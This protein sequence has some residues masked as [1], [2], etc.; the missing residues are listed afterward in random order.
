MCKNKRKNKCYTELLYDKCVRCEI[1]FDNVTTDLFCNTCKNEVVTLSN[2]IRDD[3]NLQKYF[4]VWCKHNSHPKMKYEQHLVAESPNKYFNYDPYFIGKL[5][6]V[7]YD[8]WEQGMLLRFEDVSYLNKKNK[9]LNGWHVNITDI[10][11]YEEI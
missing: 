6:Y 5:S 4:K 10:M 11:Y 7:Y 1:P 2:G 9:I 3:C 8:K